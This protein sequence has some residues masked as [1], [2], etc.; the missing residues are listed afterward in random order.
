MEEGD[1]K[2]EQ[3]GLR[4]S[5]RSTVGIKKVSKIVHRSCSI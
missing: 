2:R 1:E 3:E 5:K 4:G